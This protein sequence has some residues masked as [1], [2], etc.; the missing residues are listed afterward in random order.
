MM[1]ISYRTCAR[2]FA[3]SVTLLLM[4]ASGSGKTVYASGA[5]LKV[6]YIYLDEEGFNKQQQSFNLY[7]GASLSIENLRHRFANGAQVS[8]NF[9]NLTLNNRNIRGRLIKANKYALTLS[10]SKYRRVYAT[11]PDMY[12]RRETSDATFWVK[13]HRYVKLYGGFGLTDKNG[14]ALDFFEPGALQNSVNIDYRHTRY[15]VGIL[16]NERGRTI[17]VEYRGSTFENNL[18]PLDERKTERFRALTIFPVPNHEE[19]VVNGGFQH[20]ENTVELSDDTLSANNAWGGARIYF[21]NGIVAKYSFAFNRAKNSRDL[22]ATDNLLHA[23]SLSKNWPKVGAT[24]GL[25]SGVRDNFDDE[26]KQADFFFGGWLKASEKLTFKGDYGSEKSTVERGVT[27]T[28][29]RDYSRFRGSAVYRHENQTWY[30][31]VVRRK[32]T[33]DDIGSE[34]EFTRGTLSYNAFNERYGQINISFTAAVGEFTNSESSFEYSD[35]TIAGDILSKHYGRIQ[36]GLG[37]VFY[38]SQR[39]NDIESMSLRLRIHYKVTNDWRLE[40]VYDARNY[41][42]LQRLDSYYTANIIEIYV[43]KSLSAEEG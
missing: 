28:G 29:D 4:G 23:V 38:Q 37:G 2:L 30:G 8:G 18:N 19:I 33:N 25:R 14:E 26:L 43:I 27:L 40:G 5:E 31:K 35:K 10:H 39:D 12:T 36:L 32:I 13:P 34:S 7:E 17:Q 41:D 16:S 22:V 21:H 20:Y 24:V 6:G 11:A 9:T 42:D 3:I 1:N 15:H